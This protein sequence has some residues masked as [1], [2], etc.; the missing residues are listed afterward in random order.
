MAARGRSGPTTV[1]RPGNGAVIAMVGDYEVR[2]PEISPLSK[3]SGLPNAPKTGDSPL[4]SFE[5]SRLAM[6]PLRPA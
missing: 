2:N 1:S 3:T 4:N 5:E 6:F